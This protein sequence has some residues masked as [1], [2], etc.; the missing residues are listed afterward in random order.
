MLIYECR[1]DHNMVLTEMATDG[2]RLYWWSG[3]CTDNDSG[4]TGVRFH[5]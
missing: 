2:T 5:N 1:K 3:K 4:G